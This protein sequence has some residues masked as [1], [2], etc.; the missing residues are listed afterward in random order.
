MAEFTSRIETLLRSKISALL[1]EIE[2]PKET[3]DFAFEQQ[4]ELLHNVR[5]GID[6]VVGAKRRL[7]Q[8]EGALR[9]RAN[10]LDAQARRELAKGDDELARA[11][12]AAKTA[13]ETEL[14]T[15]DDQVDELDREMQELTKRERDISAKLEDFKTKKESLAAEATAERAEATASPSGDMTDLG[16]AM[17]RAVDKLS[18]MGDRAA[19]VEAA[20][21][22]PARARTDAPAEDPI[23]RLAELETARSVDDQLNRMR[24]E[25]ESGDVPPT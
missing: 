2:D 25:L 23:R 18:S 16:L 8:R 17:E 5:D 14:D 13:I 19:K 24:R 15:V 20:G 1:D 11:A 9:E 4:R 22:G 7:Q 3:L 21:D 10:E 12:L 6:G